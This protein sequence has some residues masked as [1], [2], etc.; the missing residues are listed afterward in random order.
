MCHFC[1][2]TASFHHKKVHGEEVQ[3]AV[4]L[5]LVPSLKFA[6]GELTT[7]LWKQQ[8]LWPEPALCLRV[9]CQRLLKWSQS[10]VRAVFPQPGEYHQRLCP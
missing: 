3:F 10:P 5:P 7:F 9:V 2:K 8:L 6:A 1:R 4:G